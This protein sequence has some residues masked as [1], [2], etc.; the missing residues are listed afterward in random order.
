MECSQSKSV[1]QKMRECKLRSGEGHILVRV[2]VN[3]KSRKSEMIFSSDIR[4]E[5][6]AMQPV[7]ER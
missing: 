6:I 2:G 4:C 5:R 1:K 3:A 7:E